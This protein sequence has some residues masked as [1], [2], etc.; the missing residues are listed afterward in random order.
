MYPA[1]MILMLV[2]NDDSKMMLATYRR[3]LM[4]P[5]YRAG[6]IIALTC[7][8]PYWHR[9]KEHHNQREISVHQQH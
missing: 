5:T 8:V 7:T 4:L 6:N 3:P 1:M 2:I 9:D